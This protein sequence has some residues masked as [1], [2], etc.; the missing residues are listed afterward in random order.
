MT[1]D[2]DGRFG[3]IVL[4]F[5]TLDGYLRKNPFFG[6]LV[7]R[8]ANRIANAEF[9]LDGTTYHISRN[10]GENSMH[11]GFRGFDKVVWRPRVVETSGGPALELTYV[12]EDGE[13]G[14]PGKLLPQP[15]PIP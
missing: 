1:P 7:G 9:T 5:D 6:A 2:R 4:G 14:Y 10:S 12:S 15:L 11:G 3:D 8:Y 13:E